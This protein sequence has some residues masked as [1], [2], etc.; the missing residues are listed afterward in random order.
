MLVQWAPG[1]SGE[2]PAQ[3]TTVLSVS[4]VAMAGFVIGLLY[5]IGA[6]FAPHIDDR[7]ALAIAAAG[8]GFP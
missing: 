5:Q 6:V 2:F 4:H 8:R 1:R 7:I 3:N